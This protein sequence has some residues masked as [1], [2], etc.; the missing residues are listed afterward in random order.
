M[1]LFVDAKNLEEVEKDLGEPVGQ[2]L[3]PLTYRKNFRPNEPFGIDNGCFSIFEKKKYFSLLEREL[4]NVANC[5]FVCVPDVVGSARR[6]LELFEEYHNHPLIAKFPRALVAQDGFEDVPI[7][8]HLIDAIFIGGTDRFKQ[9]EV[10]RQIIQCAKRLDKYIHAGRV[11]APSRWEWFEELG[12]DSC[13]GTGLAQYS[14]MRYA[15][16]RQKTEP[17]LF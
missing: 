2:L 7:P 11:N 17:K 6:T 16:F 13:D 10:S 1:K 5:R 12:V 9:S 15:I 8:W 14:N 4:K 3:T